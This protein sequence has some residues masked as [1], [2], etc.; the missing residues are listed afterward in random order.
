MVARDAQL[1]GTLVSAESIR[2]DGQAKGE[3][4]AR[5]DVILSSNGQVDGHIRVR[6]G[7]L[8]SG[9]STMDPEDAAGEA[10]GATSQEDELQMAYADAVR[11]GAEWYRSRLFGPTAEPEHE[12][13]VEPDAPVTEPDDRAP[14]Q[15]P[16]PR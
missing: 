14:A 9:R 12:R 13:A 4:A 5:K 11:R 6:Q 2:I 8:F 16:P 7:A 3:I 10:D 1:E 15:A